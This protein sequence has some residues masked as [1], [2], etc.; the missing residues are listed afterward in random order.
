MSMGHAL[1]DRIRLS[2]HCVPFLVLVGLA[3]PVMALGRVGAYSGHEIL[4]A[5]V[6]I[7]AGADTIYL[8]LYAP[9]IVRLDF[10]PEDSGASG[11]DLVVIRS[12][13]PGVDFEVR[14][15]GAAIELL[16]E[17][18]IVRVDK[19]PLRFAFFDGLGWD[20]LTE[21]DGGGLETAGRISRARFLLPAD[22][23]LY[24]T[25]ERGIGIDLRGYS[26][27]MY[28]A[29]VYGYDG[30]LEAMKINVPLLATSGGYALYF[31]TGMPGGFDLG[32]TDPGRFFYEQTSR[33]L[34]YFLLAA[35]AVAGQLERYTWLTGRQPM[36][37]KWSLGYLQSKY[38]YRT[39]GEAETMVRTMRARGIPADAVIL[40]LYW[41][42]NMG[43]LAWDV[44]AFP[45]PQ[46]M[47][48]D[49]LDLGLRTVLI[50]QPYFNEYS[51]YYHQL[52]GSL[53]AFV[54]QNWLGEAY[55]LGGWWSCNCDAVLFDMTNPDARRWLWDRYEDVFRS[56][57]AGLW[58]DLGEPERHPWDMEHYAGSAPD[59]HDVYNLLWAKTIYE[60]FSEYRPTE[61]VF[62][63]TRSGYAG[64]QRYGVFTWSGDVS[65][66]YGGLAVQVPIMLN[67]SLSGLAYHSSD[68]G[69]FTGWTSPE[70]YVRWMEFGAFNPVMRAHG[71]DNQGT[72]PWARGPEAEGIAVEFIR[73]RYSL[74]PY[75]Y[76]LAWENHETGMPITR[77]LFFH[78]P[79]D[80]HVAG[81]SDTFLFGPDILVAPVT[82]E[83]VRQREVYLPK[84]EWVDF[85]TDSLYA[86]PESVLA[87]APLD[88]I[89]LFVRAGAILPMQPVMD[90]T[91][92]APLDTLI[93]HVY[94]RLGQTR[95][96]FT[97]YE[98]D[99]VSRDYEAGGFALT[100]LAQEMIRDG[101][102][103]LLR[104]EVGE[105]A[106]SFSG[107][108]RSR[109]VLATVHLAGEAPRWVRHDSL[110][111][112]PRG[113]SDDL[114]VNGDGYFYD[115][116]SH[117]LHIKIEHQPP[118]PTAMEVGG[119]W[120]TGTRPDDDEPAGI[121][122]GANQPNPFSTSTRIP[123][124]LS[125]A[126]RVKMEIF[127]PDG[128]KIAT[129]VDGSKIPGWHSAFWDGRDLLGR[130]SAPGVYFCRLACGH[131][132]ETA[133]LILLR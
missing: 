12:P 133:K 16:T 126:C 96:V 101:A 77:P 71:V 63:L 66:S 49:F 132:A 74:L 102:D 9:D 121:G 83:G 99:G 113:S 35:P 73:L 30:P 8:R 22:L 119:W 38:G 28:N 69:G 116:A 33:G 44:E 128:K 6:R 103:T 60:G 75:L 76:S 3:V 70:L 67:T 93:L 41:F 32:R 104:V 17:D 57:I 97:L 112:L 88:R 92:E 120:M 31:D 114:M 100:S 21:P 36:P 19:S 53:R 123:Y 45:N 10:R 107:L 109:T 94:P 18:L 7:E 42:K 72:E 131:L 55:T 47:T 2:R 58:T 13:D 48:A 115:S 90:Y 23:H 111:L 25:G 34:T 43:D 64:I 85:W 91:D 78:D 127:S 14:D 125:E 117:L 130:R 81:I 20:L 46:G 51:Q 40:D 62:N 129:L 61:R 110:S 84:G 59:V 24:G 118:R 80:P 124:R 89:P 105:A 95:E 37:P 29:Q 50:T 52:T 108:P 27:G 122:L 11:T 65:R 68:L 86:G 39:R 56:G 98:D 82:V 1:V 4:P 15:T 54:A 5:G 26:F 106:G 87:D 79:Q